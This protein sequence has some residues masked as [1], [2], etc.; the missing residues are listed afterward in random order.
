MLPPSLPAYIFS[1]S[2]LKGG[3]EEGCTP[4]FL[5]RGGLGYWNAFLACV[6]TDIRGAAKQPHC[7]ELWDLHHELQPIIHASKT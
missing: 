6:Q 5:A 2:K 3:A 4:G 1:W 7:L